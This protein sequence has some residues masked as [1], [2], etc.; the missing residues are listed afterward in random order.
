MPCMLDRYVFTVCQDPKVPASFKDILSV[1]LVDKL[2]VNPR[3]SF[4]LKRVS[5]FLDK[6]ESRLKIDIAGGR[7]IAASK[8]RRNRK[9]GAYSK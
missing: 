3:R 8:P 1:G 9:L 2:A 4:Q 6:R 7:K 5:D